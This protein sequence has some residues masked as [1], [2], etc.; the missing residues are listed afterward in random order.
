MSKKLFIR[1]SSGL[2]RQMGAKHAFAKV[3]ALIVPISLYYTLIYSPSI[4]AANWFIGI[5]IAPILALPIF[6][7]YLKLAEYIPRSSG[8]YIYISRIVGPLPATIQGIANIISTPLL[9]AILSQIQVSA[10]I[11]PAFQIIGLAFHNSAL[12][13]L[14]TCILVNP[15]YFFIASLISLILM[16]IV[17]ISPQRI[18][19]NFLFAIASMQVIGALF[20][21]G[22][23]AEGNSAFVTDFNKFS[24]SFSG[25]SYSSLYSQGLSYYS[26]VTNPLQTL[27]FSILMLM[28]LFIWFFGPS[29]FAGEYKQATRSLKLGM[30]SGYTIAT[31][32]IIALTFLTAFT[33]GIPFFNYVALC[34]WGKSNPVSAGEGYIAWAG[35]MTLSSPILALLVGVLNIGIQFVAGPLS[36]AIPSRVMLAMAFDRILPEKLAYVNPRLQ[37]PLVASGVALALGIFF[38]IAILYLGFAVSTIALIAILFIYQF[39]QATISA[40]VAGFKGI[41]GVELTD[42]EKSM[43]KIYGILGS[44]ILAMSVIVAIG[45]AFVNPLYNSMVFTGNLP[46]NIALIAVIP[47]L[48]VITYFIAKK[49]R[50]SQGIELGL[51][52]KEIPPE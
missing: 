20:I 31:V 8:E 13:N 50:E 38:E 26:P 25:P 34:G 28:W 37:T 42:K 24:T 4:P 49:Y 19:G 12:F 45:Y 15:T 43:L 11:V 30:L 51:I 46:L 6:L 2:V 41:V 47:V 27:V 21:I 39:L 40:A 17:S 10:G 52:F 14:G 29:Y 44:I 48:G 23:F 7:T 18:M 35:I 9:A 32:I 5:I 16:W 1:E 33:M 3:L 36:L 22:L